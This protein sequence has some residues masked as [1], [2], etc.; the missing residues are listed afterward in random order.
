MPGTVISCLTG[1]VDGEVDLADLFERLS[2]VLQ[3][4]GHLAVACMGSDDGVDVA[5]EHRETSVVPVQHE[6]LVTIGNRPAIR[7]RW[8]RPEGGAHRIEPFPVGVHA[9]IPEGGGVGDGIDLEVVHV[10]VELELHHPVDQLARSDTGR[11]RDRRMQ[12]EQSTALVTDDSAG[13][14]RA[15]DHL[16]SARQRGVHHRIH[17]SRVRRRERSFEHIDRLVHLATVLVRGAPPAQIRPSSDKW[18]DSV[19][20]RSH[21]QE[22]IVIAVMNLP[23]H[24]DH[25]SAARRSASSFVL[26]GAGGYVDSDPVNGLS[27]RLSPTPADVC[28][29]APTADRRIRHLSRTAP[30]AAHCRGR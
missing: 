14:V 16:D 15:G 3:P 18:K 29:R 10:P 8:F 19:G 11:R 23:I 30:S 9:G 26:G 13:I 6:T 17:L 2:G 27:T 24:L 1:P 7:F 21:E 22:A 5:V 25:D 28:I 4:R 20:Q 12:R